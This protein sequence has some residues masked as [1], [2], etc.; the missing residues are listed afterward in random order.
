[1]DKSTTGM[2]MKSTEPPTCKTTNMEEEAYSKRNKVKRRQSFS[3]PKHVS[4][5][6][7]RQMKM[8]I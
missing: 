6:R 8:E 5:Q 7:T 3:G 1:L 2:V 4:K